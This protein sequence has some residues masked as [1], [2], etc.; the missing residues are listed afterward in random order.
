MPKKSSPRDRSSRGAFTDVVHVLDKVRLE[1]ERCRHDLDIQFK[2]TA[3]VQAEVEEL[4][5]TVRKLAAS[6]KA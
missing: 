5:R 2:R 1:L 3:Q 6:K 4:Q